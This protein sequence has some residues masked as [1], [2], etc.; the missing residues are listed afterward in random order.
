MSVKP[1]AKRGRPATGK[2]PILS[3]RVPAT[4]HQT[5]LD[6]ARARGVRPSDVAREVFELGLARVAPAVVDFTGALEPVV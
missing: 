1:R 4:Q 5:V 6:L 3:F 2:R